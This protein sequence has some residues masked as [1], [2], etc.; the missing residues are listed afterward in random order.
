[1]V[2][3][4]QYLLDR[5]TN[6]AEAAVI[7]LDTWQ[8]KGLGSFMFNHLVRVARSRG[9]EGFTAEVLYENR[10]MLS[11]IQRS[12]FRLG[13]RYEDGVYVIEIRFEQTDETRRPS[14][15]P[16]APAPSGNKPHPQ[17]GGPN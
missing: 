6:L 15:Q 14:A 12:G 11:I 13:T 16:A 17:G 10:N 8:N 7:V 9:V 2:A 5:N 3:L 4:S 1:M